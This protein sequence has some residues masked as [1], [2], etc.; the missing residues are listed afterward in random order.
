MLDADDITAMKEDLDEILIQ[1]VDLYSVTE[2]I[3]ASRNVAR[4]AKTVH[5]YPDPATEIKFEMQS[6]AIQLGPNENRYEQFKF[7]IGEVQ[8]N[9]MIGICSANVTINKN[10]IIYDSTRSEY[11]LV[12]GVF[13][14]SSLQIQQLVYL[15]L[16]DG[17]Q[18]W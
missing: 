4:N 3:E 15:R 7:E 13:P 8:A 18:T 1:T 5:S 10:D 2:T 11:Y 14:D 16:T 9:D 17:L 12:L 6:L